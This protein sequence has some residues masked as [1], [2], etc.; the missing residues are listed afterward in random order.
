MKEGKRRRRKGPC[1]IVWYEKSTMKCLKAVRPALGFRDEE[2]NEE[3]LLHPRVIQRRSRLRTCAACAVAHPWQ[4]ES[5]CVAFIHWSH[6]VPPQ[7]HLKTEL[8][9]SAGARRQGRTRSS[10]ANI[11]C[12][13]RPVV[14]AHGAAE[15]IALAPGCSW[16]RLTGFMSSHPP[17][18]KLSDASLR[19]AAKCRV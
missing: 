14:P 17:P 16:A 10:L 15:D 8:S 13:Q 12:A 18:P 6:C 3:R 1:S 5:S 7:T 2:Q 4:C 9:R 19:S 11:F